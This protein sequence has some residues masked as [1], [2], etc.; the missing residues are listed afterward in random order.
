MIRVAISMRVE[1]SSYG[2]RRDAL[3]QDWYQL[4]SSID[5]QPCLIPNS[6]PDP[7]VLLR[8]AVPDMLILSGGND[9]V[10][11][12]AAPER[13]ATE[14]ALIDFFVASKR[15]VLGV[16]R[17]M[18]MLNAHFG[19]RIAGNIGHKGHVARDHAVHFSGRLADGIGRTQDMVNSYH[20]QGLRRGDEAPDLE[21]GGVSD[22]GMI[23]A[24]LHASL[25]I[26]GVQWHPERTAKADDPG[27]Q[28][29]RWLA[30]GRRF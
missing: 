8:N 20:D 16:C 10:G 25:P 15:P 13:D 27:R 11:S 3:A 6:L 1:V 22:D 19:G 28:L 29:M 9:L 4:L 12:T 14:A 30:E 21:V 17:G 24:L 7:T 18:H 2:E 26:A 5:A 23:E